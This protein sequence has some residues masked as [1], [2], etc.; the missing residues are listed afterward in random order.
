MNGFSILVILIWVCPT[1]PFESFKSDVAVVRKRHFWEIVKRPVGSSKA[2]RACTPTEQFFANRKSHSKF[3]NY[4]EFLNRQI[5]KL[6]I[7]EMLGRDGIYVSRLFACEYR[8]GN[9]LMQSPWGRSSSGKKKECAFIYR[10]RIFFHVRSQPKR[11]ND[12]LWERRL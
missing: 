12:D 9:I 5:M 8:A 6:Y 11:M 2:E 1:G 7:C 10:S 4:V 3:S